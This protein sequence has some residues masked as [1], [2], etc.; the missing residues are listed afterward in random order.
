LTTVL[1]GS[2]MVFPLLPRTYTATADLLIHATNQEG[3]TTWNQSVQ[4]AL[5]DNAIQTKIDIL[6]SAPLQSQV[7]SQLN[8]MADPEFNPAIQPSWVR[9]QAQD[10]PWLAAWLPIRRSDEGL[11][12]AVLVQRHLVVRRERKSYLIQIGYTSQDPAKAARMSDILC[13]A[14]LVDQIGR[15]R[16]S[17]D[18]LLIALSESVSGFETKYR[19]DEQTE[20]E[21]REKSGLVHRGVKESMT[22]QLATL[23]TAVADAHRRTIE[24]TSRAAMLSA[25]SAKGLDAT[26][27]ALSSPL[28]QRLRERLVELGSGAGTGTVPVGATPAVVNSLRQAI[29]SETQHLVHGAQV[30]VQ[31]AQ[32]VESS[33]RGA[34]EALDA[35]MVRWQANERHADELHRTVQ[36]DLEAIKSSFDRYIQEAGRGDVLQPD[37]ELVA[38]ATMP[39]RPSF[40]NPI[41]F[42][43]GTIAL[44]ILLAGLV[45]LPSMMHRVNEHDG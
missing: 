32:N 3:A 21:F 4:D 26:Y 12:A 25:Q 9:R 1:A 27:D 17:H 11:V 19:A 45:L 15:K 28:L 8:L 5:D 40:P 42:A 33:L 35:Q 18:K 6:K 30:E 16:V 20:H 23:S 37:V 24:L 38:S 10:I 29:E 2:A 14:F 34:L 39:D 31:V 36:M 43:S 41:Y 44:A 22:R 7:I 13:Q